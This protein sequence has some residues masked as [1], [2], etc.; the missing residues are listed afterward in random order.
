[1]MS[2]FKTVFPDMGTPMV[3]DGFLV[4]VVGGVGSLVDPSFRREFSGR[5]TVRSPPSGTT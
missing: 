3:V 1:M 5:L 2:G 4:V